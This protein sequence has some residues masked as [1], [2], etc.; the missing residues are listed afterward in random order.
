MVFVVQCYVYSS[1]FAMVCRGFWGGGAN[2]SI[3][4][5]MVIIMRGG[6]SLSSCRQLLGSILYRSIDIA[7]VAPHYEQHIV[8]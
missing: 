3:T 4:R 7:K 5:K 8:Q 1:F 6:A 2:D